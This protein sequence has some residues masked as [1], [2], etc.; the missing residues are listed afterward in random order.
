MSRLGTKGHT[1]THEDEEIQVYAAASAQTERNLVKG[2]DDNET[3]LYL[4]DGRDSDSREW[5]EWPINSFDVMVASSPNDQVPEQISLEDFVLAQSTDDFCTVIRLELDR[6][7]QVPFRLD[8][9]SGAIQRVNPDEYALVV[10]VRLRKCVLL[11]MHRPAAAGQAGGRKL[12]QTI[13]RHYYWP[14]L[15]PDCYTHV[16]N[17]AECRRE[18]IKLLRTSTKCTLFPATAPLEEI[19]MELLSDLI[20]TPRGHCGRPNRRA[21]A[22]A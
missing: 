2:A 19:A 6:A 10:P 14:S 8:P 22:F 11:L 15:A 3:P 7:K 9:E 12:Y 21:A 1:T 18:R 17:C 20:Q 5:T 4:I 13:R 16:L